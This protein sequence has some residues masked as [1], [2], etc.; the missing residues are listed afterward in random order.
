[1]KKNKILLIALIGA[2]AGS[3][4]TITV[5]PLINGLPIIGGGNGGAQTTIN[6]P[7]E[8]TENV[9]KAVIKKAMPSQYFPRSR[10]LSSGLPHSRPLL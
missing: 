4:L 10:L 5:L 8:N 3:M 7:E 2:I 9:Y 6:V 1:M